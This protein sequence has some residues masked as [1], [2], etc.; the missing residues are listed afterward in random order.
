MITLRATAFSVFTFISLPFLNK[1]DYYYW[2]KKA[3]KD[4]INNIKISKYVNYRISRIQVSLFFFSQEYHETQPSKR[5]TTSRGH[6]QEPPP[7]YAV[8][9]NHF[10]A[11]N[12][13]FSDRN[14]V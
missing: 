1:V 4:Y 12:T 9:Q 14:E 6:E 13:D 7:A 2:K 8:T 5:A 10:N 11:D 3:G